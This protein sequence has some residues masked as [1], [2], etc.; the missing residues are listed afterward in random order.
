MEFEDK[1]VVL[2]VSFFCMFPTK[3]AGENVVFIFRAWPHG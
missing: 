3:Q 2:R 1:M